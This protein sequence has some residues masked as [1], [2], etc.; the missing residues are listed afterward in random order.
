MDLPKINGKIDTEEVADIMFYKLA[1]EFHSYHGI[2]TRES[3]EFDDEIRAYIK[4]V[5]D[6]IER[7]INTKG[8][9]TGDTI[10]VNGV[11][12]S[13]KFTQAGMH[14]DNQHMEIILKGV[15]SKTLEEMNETTNQ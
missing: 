14:K 15:S 4:E 3:K 2:Q 13:I 6:K 11:E 9:M 5:L 7:D 8:Y 10:K 12:Y 1:N